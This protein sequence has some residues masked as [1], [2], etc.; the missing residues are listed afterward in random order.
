MPCIILDSL[1]FLCG[2][3]RV[4]F[5]SIWKLVRIYYH[6]LLFENYIF[7]I[8]DRKT[9]CSRITRTSSTFTDSRQEDKLL[10]APSQIYR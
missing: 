4:N 10:A 3:N 9:N 1:D 5:Y 2:R 6:R 8:K 7:N